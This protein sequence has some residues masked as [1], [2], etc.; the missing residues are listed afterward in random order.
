MLMSSFILALLVHLSTS[1]LTA[2]AA[3]PSCV[4]VD[5]FENCP[6]DAHS[7]CPRGIACGCKDQIPFCKCPAYHNGWEDYWY[8]GS[9]CDQLWST[10]DLILV[11]TVPGVALVLTAVVIMQW[12]GYC[13]HK[14]AYGTGKSSVHARHTR[15]EIHYNPANVPNLVDN[16]RNISQQNGSKDDRAAQSVRF[17]RLSVQSYVNEPPPLPARFGGFSY[18]PHQRAVPVERGHLADQHDAWQSE[19]PDVD[20]KDVNPFSTM[21]MQQFPRAL[22]SAYPQFD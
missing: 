21:P 13:R 4:H 14:P 12:V 5:D 10:L 16:S 18:I 19:I 20:Y 2:Q 11:A 3:E 1:F 17:P 15:S 6:G 22:P 7:F 8:M 9:K